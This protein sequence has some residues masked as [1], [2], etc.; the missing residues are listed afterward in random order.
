[1]IID[2]DSP[3]SYLPPM[4]LLTLQYNLFVCVLLLRLLVYCFSCNNNQPRLMLTRCLN[5]F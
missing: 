4:H 1:M 5:F 3:V 2:T